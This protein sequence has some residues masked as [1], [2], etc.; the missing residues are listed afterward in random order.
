MLQN[1]CSRYNINVHKR[2]SNYIDSEPL[3]SLRLFGIVTESITSKRRIQFCEESKEATPFKITECEFVRLPLP[4]SVEVLPPKLN[5]PKVFFCTR[6]VCVLLDIYIIFLHRGFR[7]WF[8]SSCSAIKRQAH[9]VVFECAYECSPQ[10]LLLA[11]GSCAVVRTPLKLPTFVFISLSEACFRRLILRRLLV[12]GYVA[13]PHWA[14][15]T[16]FAVLACECE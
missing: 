1:E 4:E 12:V 10:S 11:F 3:L 9:L 13:L 15:S 2:S 14:A 8:I 6:T 5:L 7:K 16:V